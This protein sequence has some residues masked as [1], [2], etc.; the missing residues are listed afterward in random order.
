MLIPNAINHA[1]L[2]LLAIV[3]GSLLTGVAY[4]L[5]KRPEVVEMALEP[6]KA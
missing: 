6:A 5:L 2:Y 4:A 3:A 1:L